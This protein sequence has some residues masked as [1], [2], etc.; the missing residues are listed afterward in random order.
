[1]GSAGRERFVDPRAHRRAADLLPDCRLI[2]FPDAKHEL[3]LERDAIRS[4]WLA[5]IQSFIQE[6]ALGLE[7]AS[8]GD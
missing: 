3:F 4:E 1:M 8:L 5:A 2:S 7:A 6:K